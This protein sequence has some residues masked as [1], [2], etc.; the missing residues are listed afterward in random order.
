MNNHIEED[1]ILSLLK[2]GF[3]YC[4]II[5]KDKEPCDFEIKKENDIFYEN[6]NIE[7][8]K[9]F[10]ESLI[11][12]IKSKNLEK[13]ENFKNKFLSSIKRLIENRSIYKFFIEFDLFEIKNKYFKITIE[14]QTDDFFSL[15]LSDET[16]TIIQNISDFK[17]FKTLSKYDDKKHLTI[18]KE[19]FNYV[20]DAAEIGT[21][22]WNIQTGETEYNE[23]WAKMLG[24][25]LEE[26]APVS[27]DTWRKLVHPK[28][29]I[30][31][32]NLI[33][34]HIKG[35]LPFYSC[36]VRLKHKNGKYRWIEDK[37]KIL[38]WTEDGKPLLM[39]GIH[40]DITKLKET[41]QQLK[42][43]NKFIDMI[44][45][46]IPVR[47]FW[48]DKN[49]I[50]LGCNKLFAEDVGL[51]NPEDI[52]GKKD[53]FFNPPDD[54]ELFRKEDKQ[55]IETGKPIFSIEQISKD[56][57]GN[58]MH[59]RKHKVPLLDENNDI[60]GVLGTYEDITD[61][62]EKEK[63]LREEKE[64][65]NVIIQSI[66]DA[67]IAT[68][69]NEKVILI[70]KI[71]QTLTGFSETEALDKPLSQIYNIFDENTMQKLENPLKQVNRKNK[72]FNFK[73]SILLISKNGEKYIIE[74]SFAPIKTYENEIIGFVLVFRDV[75]E[76]IKLLMEA[77][78]ASKLESLSSL[79]AGI[80]HDFNNLLGG[81]YGFINLAKNESSFDSAKENLLMALNT[82]NR[83]KALANQLLTFSK[84]GKPLLKEELLNDII[85][86]TTIFALSGSNIEPVFTISSNLLPVLCDKNM[87][88]QVIEN[89]VINAR[90]AM[91]KY[92]KIFV[93]AKNI[94]IDPAENN[95]MKEGDYVAISIRD[96]GE[97]IL[98]EN[99]KNI[100]DPFFT[101]KKDGTGLG[102]SVC[103]SIIKQHN[104]FIEVNSEIG[105]GTEF[106]IY[107]PVFKKD[108]NE[109]LSNLQNNMNL[110]KEIIN[111]L[112]NDKILETE[113]QINNNKE[114]NDKIKNFLADDYIYKE[115]MSQKDLNMQKIKRILVL[116]DEF[117]ILK[118]ISK[119]LTKKG[120]IV[121][122]AENGE[123][124]L[125]LYYKKLNENEKYDLL[126]LDLTVQTGMGGKEVIEK[127]REKDKEI[128]AIV[129]SGYFDDPILGD[130]EKF[131][132]N[133]AIQ[134]PFILE[135][136]LNLIL[137]LQN[138]N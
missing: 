124:A 12:R 59:V 123:K 97:G 134:K 78:R 110:K 56:A 77:N 80:A 121:D 58:T 29:L 116:D 119:Y 4:K 34:R 79:A 64:K 50:Y 90:Q 49:F 60:I 118:S 63:L 76:K 8:N 33:Q 102:L 125:E 73:N 61:L 16:D 98:K 62:K 112:Q 128:L 55:V 85:H 87:I 94:K 11:S 9:R 74:D 43:K 14:Y 70:N 109:I 25:S 103:Y 131:G 10:F 100:F 23:Q 135:D 32:D 19:Y 22:K 105:K 69:K 93:E 18:E 42:D 84:G 115:N 82:L 72:I 7:E 137:S 40:A 114:L 129:S 111:N 133:K 45:N 86:D 5:Y 96:E 132:F 75:N 47:V 1:H 120:F 107:L 71:A 28:D 92:G 104:G 57:D 95:K 3:S 106:I 15:Y 21:W 108:K 27:E 24:Y 91:K 99:I 35:E 39:F 53:D 36:E 30:K 6:F 52:I 89:I 31:S 46:T 126:I 127:I 2:I 48:K 130:P 38:F 88:S 68:D 51:K 41:E 138:K 13:F 17:N 26:L 122:E 44:L 117:A 65:L 37:G 20:I 136:L 81:I 66:S 67:I 83:A 54:S 101:T 113:K